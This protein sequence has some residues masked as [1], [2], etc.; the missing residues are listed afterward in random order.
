MIEITVRPV[1]QRN[2]RYVPSF[3]VFLGQRLICESRTPLLSAAR[4]LLTEGINPEIPI[5]MSHQ[6]SDVVSI[7]STVGTAAGLTVVE[8]DS[9]APRFAQYRPLSTETV[10][11]L[12][13]PQS[14]AAISAEAD[15]QEGLR[16]SRLPDE[17][18][19]DDH[20]SV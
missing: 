5:T 12:R 18:F 13:A 10:V 17:A 11:S 7:R 9:E 8:K 4:I 14:L 16:L 19:S 20:A 2:G 3:Q 6:G 1:G 15:A